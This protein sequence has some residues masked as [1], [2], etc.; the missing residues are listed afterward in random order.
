MAYSRLRA[1]RARKIGFF[2]LI[3][4]DTDPDQRLHLPSMPIGIVRTKDHLNLLQAR[5]QRLIGEDIPVRDCEKYLT[6]DTFWR[7]Q[8]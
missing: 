8:G 6:S 3:V 5:F 7:R 1:R 2:S 4:C